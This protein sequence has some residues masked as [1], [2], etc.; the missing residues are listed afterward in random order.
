MKY[1][2]NYS[3]LKKKYYT[4]IRRY[5]KGK[6][7]DVVRET[8]PNGYHHAKIIQVGRMK[9]SEITTQMLK[10]D[11]DVNSRGEFLELINSFYSKPILNETKV[12][13]YHL[14]KLEGE[15]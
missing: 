6:V 10:E 14:V 15:E 5:P 3:K 7:G 9:I 8:Y 4:T 2:H 12:Y 11:A 13:V 1:S